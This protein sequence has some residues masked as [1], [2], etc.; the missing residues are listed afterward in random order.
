MP[1]TTA[2]DAIAMDLDILEF[3]S[4]PQPGATLIILHGLGADGR[5]FLPFCGELDLTRT[6]P[7]RFV[8]P[9]APVMPV[10]INGGY[11]MPAWYDILPTDDP[12]RREDETSL[13]ASRGRIDALIQRETARGM[14]AERIVL[15][16]FSQGCAMALLTGLRHPDKLAGIV[17]LSGYLPL[18]ETTE[19]ERHTANLRTPIFMAHGDQDDVV[20]MA[21]GEQARDHLRALGH[22][23]SWHSYPMAHGLC[24]DEV[25]DIQSFL[26]RVLGSQIKPS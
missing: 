13:R 10:S 22:E 12:A 15:M 19:A 4:A 21:R 24:M 23:V 11:E 14:P 8:L 6:G 17:A 3:E 16:G 18:L 20:P 9:N 7:L 25:D 1:R 5:D 2:P 26:D